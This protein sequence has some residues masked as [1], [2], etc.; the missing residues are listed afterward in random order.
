MPGSQSPP[1]LLPTKIHFR[2]NNVSSASFKSRYD[3]AGMNINAIVGTVSV[4][5][6]SPIMGTCAIDK[7]APLVPSKGYTVGE[8]SVPQPSQHRDMWEHKKFPTLQI[9]TFVGSSEW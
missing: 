5:R 3:I 6:H 2:D 7:I 4:P 1:A 9:Q 8:E